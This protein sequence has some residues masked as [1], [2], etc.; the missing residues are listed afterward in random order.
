MA[1]HECD[2]PYHCD[3]YGCMAPGECP[4]EGTIKVPGYG[5]LCPQCY[6]EIDGA[7]TAIDYDDL[8][9]LDA[10]GNPVVPG[11][12]S[13]GGEADTPDVS[14]RCSTQLGSK[15][16]TGEIRSRREAPPEETRY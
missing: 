3:D 8:A 7:L 15:V 14:K 11:R 16:E 9:V 6:D 13:E 4:N 5:W 2:C 12:H 10:E 1:Y